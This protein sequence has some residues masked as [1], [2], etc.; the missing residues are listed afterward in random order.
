MA[1]VL[2]ARKWGGIVSRNAKA[3]TGTLTAALGIITPLVDKV[4]DVDVSSTTYIWV[5]SG[6]AALTG[7][8]VWL[9]TNIDKVVL[10]ADTTEKSVEEIT[11][12]DV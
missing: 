8:N 4:G 12:R 6:V 1:K 11:G 2:P 3:V 10:L 7:F 9:T 5:A